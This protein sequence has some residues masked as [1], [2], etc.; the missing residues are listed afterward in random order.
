MRY[1][2]RTLAERREFRRKRPT[3]KG[4]TDTRRPLV[5]T[6]IVPDQERLWQL[7]REIED[8]AAADGRVDG[9]ER[10]EIRAA[11]IKLCES[12]A[13][14][15]TRLAKVVANDVIALHTSYLNYLAFVQSVQDT[16]ATT[17]SLNIVTPTPLGNPR[18]LSGMFFY[19]LREYID[20]GFLNKS[21]MPKALT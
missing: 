20:A 14:E 3:A 4:A 12:V 9:E 16:G 17:S 1:C 11:S 19:T 18:D 6:I 21:D 13:P 2:S 7:Q 8:Y 15:H 10:K 5:T